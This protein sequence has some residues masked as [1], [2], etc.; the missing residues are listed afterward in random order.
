M[1]LTANPQINPL[2]FY[3]I[4]EMIWFYFDIVVNCNPKKVSED[5]VQDETIKKLQQKL[6]RGCLNWGRGK[7]TYT[8][9]VK[10]RKRTPPA[11]NTLT[12]I[13]QKGVHRNRERIRCFTLT[14]LNCTY[15]TVTSYMIKRPTFISRVLTFVRIHRIMARYRMP[16]THIATSCQ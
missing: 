4:V 10:L 3:D 12:E 6:L 16:I 7:T 8:F 1:R 15:D 11:G 9:S 13:Q 2:N 5:L 14:R